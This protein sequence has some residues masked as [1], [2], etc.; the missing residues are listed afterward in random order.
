MHD[1][2]PP[3]LRRWLDPD[4]GNALVLLAFLSSRLVLQVVGV[5]ARGV[6]GPFVKD[7]YVWRYHDSVGWDIW[8][9]LDTGWYLSIVEQGYQLYSAEHL[10]GEAVRMNHAFFP[11]YPVVVKL[12]AT[13]VG[14][15]LVAGVVVSNLCFLGALLL[16]WRI[17]RDRLDAPSATAVVFIAA[18]FPGSYV[19]S[20]M[21]TESLFLV[22]MLGCVHYAMKDRWLMVGLLGALLTATRLVGLVVV[23]PLGL[24]YVER[25]GW[26]ALRQARSWLRLSAL[27][28]VP[29]GLL[30]YMLFLHRLVGNP[31]S[32]ID[33]Q[34]AW[35][36]SFQSPL[37][38]FLAPLSNPTHY[39][40]FQWLFG[41]ACWLCLIPLATRRM[42]PELS[43][44]ACLLF[45]P[46][47]NGAPY[48]PLESYARYTIVAYPVFYGLALLVKDRP[49]ARAV[50]LA[51]M[52]T[53][54]GFLMVC[55]ATGMFFV[56]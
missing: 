15:P 18:F 6:F 47:L 37:V 41:L 19:F 31:L 32:F 30:L 13:L 17:T 26:T 21:Y 36:R 25:H 2:L 45:I 8:G 12:V 11:G 40:L 1:K 38:P 35:D 46:L 29:L 27:A 49:E 42:W 52:A 33:V 28:L 44:A 23:L 20:A 14:H 3:W 10:A 39:N 55:W 34:V 53:L 54:N 9:V 48:A 4:R 22:L 43:L 5:L 7:H 56:M 51:G 16:L 50:M 24:L